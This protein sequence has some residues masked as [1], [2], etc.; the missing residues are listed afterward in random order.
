MMFRIDTAICTTLALAMLATALPTGVQ[1]RHDDD[2][3]YNGEEAWFGY[4]LVGG[5]ILGS[6]ITSEV[7]RNRSYG[8]YY[9]HRYDSR[10]YIR[11]T[12]S[13]CPPPRVYY[14][15]EPVYYAPQ[16]VYYVAPPPTVVYV[17][18]QQPVYVQ[19]QQPTVIQQQPAVQAQP[20]QPQGTSINYAPQAQVE[21]PA[22]RTQVAQNQ[23]YEKY[24]EDRVW[25]FW[26]KT[27]Q[28]S[29]PV[30]S[31]NGTGRSEAVSGGLRSTNARQVANQQPIVVNNYYY[32]MPAGAEGATTAPA[33]TDPA[34]PGSAT[35]EGPATTGYWA[36]PATTATT[37]I[38]VRNQSGSTSE[39]VREYFPS[40][41]SA[42]APAP[43]AAPSTTATAPVAPAPA[44]DDTTV[45]EGDVRD[46]VTR[47]RQRLAELES[48]LPEETE[49]KAA[50][51]APAPAPA[52]SKP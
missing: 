18:A 26:R 16:P 1:A 32:T 2:K 15:P 51:S 14:A 43:N 44:A 37:A 49:A 7:H 33:A 28:E 42:P 6:V 40:T 13:Y 48:M 36:P 24:S 3:W 30:L 23:T 9:E 11:P 4:G 39:K 8:G 25:P 41:V 35:S 50:P 27:R 10:R 38:A 12:Y 52:T 46:E 29:F 21:E 22:P 5:A 19:Q 47:L 45:S 20:A 31:N 34:A 17:P